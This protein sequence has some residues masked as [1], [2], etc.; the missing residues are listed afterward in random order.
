MTVIPVLC[1]LVML[2]ENIKNRVQYVLRSN[3]KLAGSVDGQV[4]VEGWEIGAHIW[5]LRIVH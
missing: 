2:E 3:M 5:L 1:T 4:S